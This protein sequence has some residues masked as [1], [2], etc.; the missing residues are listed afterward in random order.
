MKAKVMQ[1]GIVA[2]A[3]YA[4]GTGL[5]VVFALAAFLASAVTSIVAIAVQAIPPAAAAAIACHLV[6]RRD[7]I[8]TKEA[9]RRAARRVFR[10]SATA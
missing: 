9:V 4:A 10:R 7:G 6:A 3:I 8:T 1:V 2:T 5:L